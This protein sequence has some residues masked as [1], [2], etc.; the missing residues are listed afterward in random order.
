MVTLG[1]EV[2]KLEIFGIFSKY[3]SI[4]IFPVKTVQ[5]ATG[6]MSKNYNYVHF[7]AFFGHN[8]S[9]DLTQV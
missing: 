9:R 7:L 4:E 3:F 2:I 8:D 5:N 1:S 6:T